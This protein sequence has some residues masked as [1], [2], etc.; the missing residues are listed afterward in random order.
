ML[1]GLACAFAQAPATLNL[2]HDLVANGIASQNMVPNSPTLDARPLFQAGISYASKN[3]IPT[4][5]AD[6]GNYYFLT[7]NSAFQHV[8]LN[9]IANVT[10]DL[11][12]SDLYFQNRNIMGIQLSNC[13]NF[14]MKDF[15]A[16]YLELP[17]TQVTV[18]SVNASTRTIS[19]TPN[20]N[21]SPPSAFNTYTPPSGYVDDGF[22]V[23]VF[24]NGEELRGTGRMAITGPLS[25]SSVQITDASP[26]AQSAEVSSIQPGD[27][28][29]I[30]RRSG[31]GTIFVGTSTNTRI[32]N[33]SVYAS[34]FIGVFTGGG[35]S[36]T[37]NQVQVI[38]RPGSDRLISSN[39]DGIHIGG[40]GADNVILNNTVRRGCDDAI[41]I[42]GEWSAIVSAPNNGAN[43]QVTRNNTAPIPIGNAFDF[44]NITNATVV[45]TATVIAEN[46]PPAQQTGAAGE[47]ITLTL[48]HAISGL[49]KNF[50]VTEDDP[51]LRGGGTVIIGNLVEE[52]VFARGIYPAGVSNVTV[53]DNLVRA[54]NQSGILVE[55]DEGLAYS[56]KTGPS[57]GITIKNNIV[58][59][60][61]GYG[62]PSNPLL[63]AAASI[64]VVAYDQNF[65]W[66]STSPFSNISVT[67]NFITNSIRSGVR[68]DNVA[69]G[70]I[71]GNNILIYGTDPTDYLWYLPA[72][73]ETQKQVQNDFT[74]ATVVTASS[75]VTNTNNTT[76]GQRVAN[77]SYAASGYHLAPGSIAVAYGHGQSFVSSLILA[78]IQPLP[79][80]LGGIT[81][82][83]TDS[84]G[85]S[86]QAGLYYVSPGAVCYV[87]PLGTAPGVATVT[88]GNTV[89][90][91]L[92]GSV[93]P[94]IATANGNGSGV[95]IAAAVLASNGGA[96]QVSV[97]VFQCGSSGCVPVPMSLGDPSDVLV[98]E[99]F[100]TGIRG[101]SGLANVSI[102]IGG[103]PAQLAYAGANVA[104]A[105]FDQINVIVPRSLAAAGAVPLVLTIDGVTA[106]VVTVALQ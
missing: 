56:Y 96:K 102:E 95:P 83:V 61:L 28:L 17:F 105:G 58:D 21:Y 88:I 57:T 19:Y 77:A 3:H 33:V 52:E 100:G 4:V 22:Y 90:G 23:F 63:G 71:A 11:Q 76:T 13:T 93:A 106:N 73:C 15:T 94:E 67:G 97:P 26:W 81:V 64:D 45:G 74:Q 37:I 18:R 89:S 14:T 49:Q 5:I 55:M 47:L 29:V 78:G 62:V 79:L 80:T 50:G 25:D 20:P 86:R 10:V 92:I 87:V 43:V 7:Q 36:L 31:I 9:G 48:D 99:L 16:D 2:S 82:T 103:V 72:C 59:S 38:P 6:R 66:V 98:L 42:D 8:F 46:P 91:A 60:A 85:V 75:S 32:Q 69:G 104:Y 24:R 51:N 1:L 101:H 70:Q 65:A 40:A 12:Y 27:T 68:L 41:A 35:S 34:G 30:E 53:T 44:I 84:Q 54:T 39:A